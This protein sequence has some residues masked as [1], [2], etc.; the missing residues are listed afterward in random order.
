[1]RGRMSSG[2][3]SVPG[4]VL[5]GSIREQSQGVSADAARSSGWMLERRLG[6]EVQRERQGREDL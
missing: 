4:V 5:D 1:M 3:S 6:V 2:V